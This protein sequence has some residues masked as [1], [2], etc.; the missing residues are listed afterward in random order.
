VRMYPEPS[1]L[2]P[3]APAPFD[4]SH[5]EDTRDHARTTGNNGQRELILIR[6]PVALLEPLGAEVAHRAA[7]QVPRD[8]A[9]GEEPA[10]LGVT[11]G[12][13]VRHLLADWQAGV[14]P[15]LALRAKARFGLVV[16]AVPSWV[17]P[18]GDPLVPCGER[19]PSERGA[20]DLHVGVDPHDVGV[21]HLRLALVEFRRHVRMV[22]SGRVVDDTPWRGR[23][24]G[25]LVGE[26]EPLRC[27]VLLDL[28]PEP[29]DA[30]VYGGHDD[31]LSHSR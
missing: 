18:H 7:R 30:A 15:A 13:V 19:L 31:Y 8:G 10:M 1:V 16:D 11:L 3:A 21:A 23:R 27:D 12:P 14:L 9:A 6:P 17:A 28:G 22:V 26:T 5:R 29:V 25:R 4:L 24:Q 2:E 20:G